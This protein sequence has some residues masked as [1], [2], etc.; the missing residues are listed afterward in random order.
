MWGGVCASDQRRT[1]GVT[2]HCL[3]FSFESG[4]LTE[5]RPVT[6]KPAP[7]LLSPPSVPLG[8]EGSLQPSLA[9]Y[10]GVE[11]LNLRTKRW[12]LLGH[13]PSPDTWVFF[14]FNLQEFLPFQI[15]RL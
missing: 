3:P 14:F 15:S 13:L 4:P 8:L 7:C 11:D 1:S 2:H 10:T 12:Y 5:P 6:S 9:S